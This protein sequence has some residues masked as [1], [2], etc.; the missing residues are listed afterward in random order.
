M[1]TGASPNER[2]GKQADQTYGYHACSLPY[3]QVPYEYV[4]EDWA[5]NWKERSQ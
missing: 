1:A 2:G 4:F 3:N 5:E